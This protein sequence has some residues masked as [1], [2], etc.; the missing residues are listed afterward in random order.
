M[1]GDA[2][3]LG[4]WGQLG[5]FLCP[6]TSGG[7]YHSLVCCVSCVVVPG[8][9]CGGLLLWIGVL[10][11][12]VAQVGQWEHGGGTQMTHL[13]GLPL[14]GSPLSSVAPQLRPARLTSLK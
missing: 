6:G 7:G 10:C 11:D 14:V 12:V 13:A 4:P 9:S 8:A 1:S 3:C 5:R 2:A